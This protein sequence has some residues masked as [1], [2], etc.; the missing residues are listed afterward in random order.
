M[1]SFEAH[2]FIKKLTC[3]KFVPNVDLIT[4]LLYNLKVN[5][6][7]NVAQP[8]GGGNYCKIKLYELLLQL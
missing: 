5:K 8:N 7:F 4:Y 6:K 2:F 3:Y 1:H